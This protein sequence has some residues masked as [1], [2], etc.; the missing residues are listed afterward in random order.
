MTTCTR[1]DETSFSEIGA[2]EC[3]V[4]EGGTVANENNNEC[5]E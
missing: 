4:C 5:G 1:C 3:T 2:T